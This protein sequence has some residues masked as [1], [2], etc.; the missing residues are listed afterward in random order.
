MSYFEGFTHGVV[1][2]NQRVKFN[3]TKRGQKILDDHNAAVR[4]TS[5]MLSGYSATKIGPDGMHVMQLYVA[6]RVFGAAHII[7]MESAFDNCSFTIL[8]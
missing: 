3:L 1:N 2:I 6:M 8:R 5:N 4:A 7:G